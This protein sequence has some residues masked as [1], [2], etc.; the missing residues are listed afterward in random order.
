MALGMLLRNSSI[1]GSMSEV[2][3]IAKS[4][5]C[6]RLILTTKTQTRVAANEFLEVIAIINNLISAPKGFFAVRIVD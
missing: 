1:P 3:K 6:H 2:C 5:Q 4:I